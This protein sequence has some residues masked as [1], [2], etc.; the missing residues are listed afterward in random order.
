MQQILLSLRCIRAACGLA[1]LSL[2]FCAGGVLAPAFSAPI[3]EVGP[4]NSLGTLLEF[5]ATAF[6]NARNDPTPEI[7]IASPQIGQFLNDQDDAQF[8]WAGLNDLVITVDPTTNSFS[9]TLTNQR[10]SQTV[11]LTNLTQTLT[12]NGSTIEI[13]D[14]NTID[15]TIMKQNANRTVNLLDLLIN[16]MS[17]VGGDD[18]IGTGNFSQF[19][20]GDLDFSQLFTVTA[21]VE[22]AGGFNNSL[23]NLIGIFIGFE[24]PVPVSAP[25]IAAIQ[26]LALCCLML[27]V[28]RKRVSR[29][30]LLLR[31]P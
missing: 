19:H 24:E 31:P 2:F 9:A 4:S 30:L 22:L 15:I 14:L 6:R 13:G 18:I 11:I 27:L 1:L 8:R 10:N 25:S 20:L 7:T 29:L 5:R 21:T 23:N 26:A 28:Q 3:I 16:G 12:I 17:P